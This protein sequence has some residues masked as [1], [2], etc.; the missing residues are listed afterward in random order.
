MRRPWAPIGCVLWVV[1]AGYE[2]FYNVPWKG[3]RKFDS[4]AEHGDMD[5]CIRWRMYGVGLLVCAGDAVCV[6][7]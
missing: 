7:A 4:I 1:G 2:E 3:R 6:S 5:G